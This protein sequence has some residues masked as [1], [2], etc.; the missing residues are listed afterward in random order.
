MSWYAKQLLRPRVKVLVAIFFTILFGFCASSA[1]KFEQAFSFTDVLP[2]DSYVTSFSNSGRQ[3]TAAGPISVGVYFRDVDQSDPAVRAQ[4]QDY[5]DALLETDYC[6][7]EP[8]FFWVSHFDMFVA[9]TK[10]A[11]LPFV[12]QMDKFLGNEIFGKM[13]GSSIS[14]DEDGNV[15]ASKTTI[16]MDV[17][18]DD[19]HDQIE[20]L[21]S[22]RNVSKKHPMNQGQDEFLFFTYDDAYKVRGKLFLCETLTHLLD[23][24]LF[25]RCCQ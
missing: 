17:D 8:D 9:I 22:Q 13:Y 11:E 5:I 12:Q 16:N 24:G 1:A 10:S 15:Y 2:S 21:F 3:Y 14:R 19:V 20:A 7:R 25:L 23:V 4:M 6:N 18:L